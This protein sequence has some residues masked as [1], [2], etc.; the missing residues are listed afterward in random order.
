MRSTRQ[1]P[2]NGSENRGECH[3]P[4]S[5]FLPASVALTPR[6][7]GVTLL[8]LIALCAACGGSSQARDLTPNQAACSRVSL[9]H[10]KTP[11]S[12][13]CS[14]ALAHAL[15]RATGSGALMCWVS[16][17]AVDCVPRYHVDR[18]QVRMTIRNNGKAWY[19]P[20]VM[21]PKAGT[22]HKAPLSGV[23]T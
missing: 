13:A 9:S 10:P 17:K 4:R 7:I 15:R 22:F 23:I 21:Y 11:D 2:A 5:T 16:G 1:T 20:G 18:W 14:K 3:R 19:I 12:E 6:K 8:A